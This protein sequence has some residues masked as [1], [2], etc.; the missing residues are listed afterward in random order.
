MKALRAF[1]LGLFEFRRAFTTHYDYPELET[2]DTGR[3]LA[4]RLTY[5]WFEQ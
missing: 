2:Y 1:L 3:E 5:R 4:H